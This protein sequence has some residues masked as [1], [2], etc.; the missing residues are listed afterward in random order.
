MFKAVC[1]LTSKN[2]DFDV[3]WANIPILLHSG[4][5]RDPITRNLVPWE[6]TAQP[7]GEGALDTGG[8]L[9]GGFGLTVAD[10]GSSHSVHC[11]VR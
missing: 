7:P 4:T 10:I 5:E 9:V 3:Q 11:V 1:L 8:E 6:L 2:K